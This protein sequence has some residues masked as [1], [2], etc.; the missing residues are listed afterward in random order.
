MLPRA[1][2]ARLI[3]QDWYL[4]KTIRGYRRSRWNTILMLS[5]INGSLSC[6]RRFC[7]GIWWLGGYLLCTFEIGPHSSYRLKGWLGC[8]TSPDS[9]GL[10]VVPEIGYLPVFSFKFYAYYGHCFVY[11]SLRRVPSQP[12]NLDSQYITTVLAYLN[13]GSLPRRTGT[14][15]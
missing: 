7:I 4:R 8:L 15:R 5:L 6:L 12:T 13:Y 14:G 2:E 1:I 3:K 9:Q 11:S 10:F